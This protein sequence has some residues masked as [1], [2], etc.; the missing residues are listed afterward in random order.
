MVE[1]LDGLSERYG[2]EIAPKAFGAVRRMLLADRRAAARRLTSDD[3]KTAIDGLSGVLDR[4]DAWDV[5]DRFSTVKGGLGRSFRKGRKSLGAAYHD[6]DSRAFHELRKAAKDLLYQVHVLRPLWPGLLKQFEREVGRATDLLGEEHDL[7]ALATWL[8]AHE[9]DLAARY[10]PTTFF[11][12][13]DQRRLEARAEAQPLVARIYAERP[14]AFARR[15]HGYWTASRDSLGGDAFG[16]A[17]ACDG[18]GAGDA[19]VLQ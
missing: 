11:G 14:K 12:I 9:D 13:T 5:D 8:S 10:E 16:I 1:T 2:G 17:R 7:A 18:D 6:L 19:I 3:V 4:V 15:I